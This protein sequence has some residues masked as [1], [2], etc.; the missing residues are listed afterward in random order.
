MVIKKCIVGDPGAVSWGRTKWRDE[1][2]SG[3]FARPDKLPLGLR[4]WV[5]SDPWDIKGNKQPAKLVFRGVYGPLRETRKHRVD[6]SPLPLIP[7]FYT[8]VTR[9]LNPTRGNFKSN[10]KNL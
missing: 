9:H 8:V 10:A 1:K 2:F 7:C 6:F 3:H 5:K 4:G